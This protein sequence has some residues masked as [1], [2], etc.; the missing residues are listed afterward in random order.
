M[1]T[2]SKETLYETFHLDGQRIDKVLEG[3]QHVVN[4][5]NVRRLIVKNAAG[6]TLVEAPLT[7]GVVGAALA[8]IWAAVG[9]I[10]AIATDCTITVEKRG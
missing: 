2:I 5:G 10:A 6:Q 1:V 4:E 8:P 9:A 3:V 7:V